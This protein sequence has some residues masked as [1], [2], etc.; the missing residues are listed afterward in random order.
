[1]RIHLPLHPHHFA[2]AG[3]PLAEIGGELVVIELQ[4]ELSWEGEQAGGVVGVLGLDRPLPKPYAVIRRAEDPAGGALEGDAEDEESDADNEEE[5][6]PKR[7]A[8]GR[9]IL[10]PLAK[11][12]R[13]DEDDDDEPPLFPE[14]NTPQRPPPPLPPSSPIS[15][16]PSSAHDY[17]SDLDSSPVMG[18]GTL[19]PSEFDEDEAEEEQRV[20]HYEVVGVVRK[21]IVFAL[22][23]EPLVQPTPLPE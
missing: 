12:R 23:P 13:V 10:G 19:P 5:R 15:F 22:R 17:S 11:K 18:F 16:H 3:G 7:P 21:K 2:Q 4:G 6:S 20:R 8:G 9:D 1:M 14:Q